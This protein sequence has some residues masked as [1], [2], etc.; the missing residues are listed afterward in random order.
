MNRRTFIEKSAKASSLSLISL[1]ELQQSV[2]H[3][4]NGQNL[5]KNK[6]D[7][8]V[9]GVGSMG[10]ST[11]YQLAKRGYKVLGL[12]Q[13]NLPHDKGSHSGQSRIIRKAYFEHPNYVPL[14]EKAYK[15]WDILQNESGHKIYHKTGLLYFGKSN[16]GLLNSVQSSSELYGIPLKKVKNKEISSEYK[17][18]N[19]PENFKGLFE[20][21][22]G[23]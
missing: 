12:E 4:I 1:S 13:F 2:N 21:D 10:S 6:F 11:C 15:N 19:I 8:I 9:L 16:S 23:F 5:K 20:P 18:F 7:V 22:A 3:K 17:Q 14:L